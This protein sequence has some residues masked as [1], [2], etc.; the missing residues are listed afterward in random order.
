LQR[1]LL[2]PPAYVWRRVMSGRTRYIAVTGSLGKTTAKELIASCLAVQAPI[3]K[4]LSNDNG[5]VSLP[6]TL[7][8]VRPR[9]RFAVVETGTKGPGVL[10][11]IG[12]F[13]RPDIAVVTLVAMEHRAKFRSLEAIAKE[14]GSLPLS[15]R[16]GGV[17]LLNGDD[18]HV[19]AMAVPAGVSRRVFGTSPGM[20]MRASDVESTWPGRLS[21][22]AHWRE[23]SARVETQLVGKH[24]LGGC[25]AALAV[26]VECG[27]S[28]GDA[29]KALSQ[30]APTIGR[31]QPAL[32]PNGAVILRD[33]FKGGVDTLKPALEVLRTARAG[34]RWIVTSGFEESA[35]GETDRMKQLARQLPGVADY[36]LFVGEKAGVGCTRAIKEG[37]SQDR[38]FHAVSQQRAV[39]VL[40]A[41]LEPGD[42]VLLKGP[43]NDHL[44]RIYYALMEHKY[45]P[46]ACWVP[47]CT[48]QGICDECTDLHGRKQPLIKIGAEP[49]AGSMKF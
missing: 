34:R 21:F 45:G 22:T 48:K 5:M 29:A 4:S 7:L 3:V 18:P 15:V 2:N 35:R 31:L 17:V 1:R 42:L 44:T 16:P 24:W 33:D 11:R 46:V 10:R 27:M 19:A 32:L 28:L 38:V 8:R 23:Q 37:F 6:R 25:L 39:E 26:S 30:T 36:V 40:R 47:T 13:L 9:H 49:L 12:Q 41:R 43:G 14:K 20:D